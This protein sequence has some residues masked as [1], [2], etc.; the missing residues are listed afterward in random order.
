[1]KTALAVAQ[2]AK[3]LI[4][5]NK[6][7]KKAKKLADWLLKN[8]ELRK[9]AEVLKKQ[10]QNNRSAAEKYEPE[11]YANELFSKAKKFYQSA[12]KFYNE[13]KFAEAKNSFSEA[14]KV[15]ERSEKT[16]F[17]KKLQFLTAEAGKA[18]KSAKWNELKVWASKIRPLNNSLAKQFDNKADNELRAIAVERELSA[19]R[20]EKAEKNWLKVY[21]YAMAAQ[22]IDRSSNEAQS[23]KQEAE[24]YLIPE[25]K[26]TATVNN[27]VVSAQIVFND[28]NSQTTEV[29]IK[30]LV[31]G[32][33]YLAKIKY[34]NSKGL[35]YSGEINFFC[36]WKSLL[37]KKIELRELF[38]L[39][40][41]AEDEKRGFK[42]SLDKRTLLET[43]QDIKN[44]TIP[45]GVLIIGKDAFRE[46]KNLTEVII[47]D[48]V[49]HIGERAFYE[50]ENLLSIVIPNG[51][52]HIGEFA[53]SSCNN[54]TEVVIPN[55]VTRIEEGAFAYCPELT[56][57]ILPGNITRIER[58]TFASCK[59]L[60][61]VI[62]PQIVHIGTNA[63][64][65]IKSFRIH[66]NN[67]N[68][69]VDP[70]GVL[71]NL[72]EKIV[73]S[74]PKSLSGNYA[75][76]SNVTHIGEKAFEDCK[77]LTSITIPAGVTHIGKEAFRGCENLTSISIPDSVTHIGE[78]AFWMCKKLDF[79]LPVGVIHIGTGAIRRIKSFRLHPDN[80]NFRLDS[81]GVLIN[82][83]EKKIVSACTSISGRYSIPDGVTC[84]GKYAFSDCERLTRLTIPNSVTHI[85]TGA[86]WGCVNLTKIKLPNSITRIEERV[87]CD[88]KKL[89]EIIIPNSVSYI[90]EYAFSDCDELT[91]VTIPDSVT[92][93]GEYVFSGCDSLTE[94]FIPKSITHWGQ[95][96]F[97]NCRKLTSVSIEYGVS[98]IGECAFKGCRKLN[99]VTI[100]NSV[101]R[102]E[103]G[104][105]WDCYGLT[106]ISIPNS[107]THIGVLAFTN[108]ACE[109]KIKQNYSHLYKY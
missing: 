99:N 45:D 108:T 47:S 62:P 78:Y 38:D 21:H 67:K 24:K 84:I 103:Y 102:I 8:G 3:L 34:R 18:E 23:L 75:I 81:K 89:T 27:R 71:L 11:T 35:L 39:K 76:S 17:D 61:L 13:T 28:G 87:F 77:N 5:A 36:N 69:L 97:G 82:L 72:L 52:T 6:E 68:F 85:E 66:P 53:F 98:Y 93:I 86:F 100:P 25:L 64:Y 2:E 57:I 109:A 80:K 51:V 12:E 70:E 56:K 44:Y 60:E 31:E 26:I 22:K 101:T 14:A 46:R 30:N 4:T 58:L 74:A 95:N 19:A 59:K 79:E 20:K 40:R 96:A 49:T 65:D 1:M 54:L 7:Y 92:H 16:A 33:K 91:E 63:L 41:I 42:F 29:P 104:A 55:G 48:S 106:H 32:K 107:V 88:C 9:N 37:E 43:P 73:I 83:L 105:F 90:G 50:C 10:A 94:I 15:F